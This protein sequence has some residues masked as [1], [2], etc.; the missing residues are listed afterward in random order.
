MIA[1]S[2][3]SILAGVYPHSLARLCTSQKIY[4]R[5]HY[6]G[7]YPATSNAYALALLTCLVIGL[8]L[9]STPI[10]AGMLHPR[11]VTDKFRQ[12]GVG[13]DAVDHCLGENSFSGRK[14]V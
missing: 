12:M 6:L 4:Q 5:L 10:R 3:S 2:I 7:G 8:T 13:D 9:V 1:E 14:L 11:S